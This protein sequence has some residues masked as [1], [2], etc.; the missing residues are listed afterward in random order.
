MTISSN[1]TSANDDHCDDPFTIISTD[2]EIDATALKLKS[3]HTSSAVDAT[4]TKLAAELDDQIENN[5]LTIDPKYA[6]I[7]LASPSATP[8][9]PTLPSNDAHHDLANPLQVSDYDV[10][11]QQVNC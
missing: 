10:Y 7:D 3:M 4:L 5:S 11:G 8:G 9:Q 6:M 1:P 2:D